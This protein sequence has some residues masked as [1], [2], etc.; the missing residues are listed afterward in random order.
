MHSIFLHVYAILTTENSF[1]FMHFYAKSI[2]ADAF[3]ISHVYAMLITAN[4]YILLHFYAKSI[5]ADAIFVFCFACLRHVNYGK[6]LRQ[7]NFG[8]CIY[9]FLMLKIC[10]IRRVIFFNLYTF[11]AM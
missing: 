2:L 11:Y 6:F 7:A 10:L 1:N 4:L 8:G 9:C 5:L 3:I